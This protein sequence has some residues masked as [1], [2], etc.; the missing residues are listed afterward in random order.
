V[1]RHSF[2]PTQKRAREASKEIR[3]SE[4]SNETDWWAEDSFLKLP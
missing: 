1:R 4:K 3:H 2:R